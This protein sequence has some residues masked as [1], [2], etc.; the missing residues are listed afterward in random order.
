[1]KALNINYNE[2]VKFNLVFSFLIFYFFLHLFARNG[3][4]K[5]L[6]K[7]KCLK[8]VSFFFVF[9][10]EGN[11]NLLEWNNY[12]LVVLNMCFDISYSSAT[13]LWCHLN[14][15]CDKSNAYFKFWFLVCVVFLQ[16]FHFFSFINGTK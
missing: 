13:K 15:S 4:W 1:M 11:E 16:S 2:F 12:R 5:Y 3:F 8:I 6:K 10:V 14:K 7:C 9:N